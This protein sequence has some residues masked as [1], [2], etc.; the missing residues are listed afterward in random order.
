[1]ATTSPLDEHAQKGEY[2]IRKSGRPFT[3][4]FRVHFVRAHDGVPVSPFH[5]IP[6]YHDREK[7]ILNMVIE[8]PRWSNAKFEISREKSLN[9]IVQDTLDHAPRF[10]K[11]FFPY[12][13]YIWNY[14]AL[15]QTWEDPDHKDSDTGAPGDNDPLDACEIGRAVAPGPGTVRRVRPLGVLGLLD[16][17]ETDWKV[18]V[19]DVDD[20]VLGARLRDLADV[21]RLLP[22]LLDATRDWF[23]FYMVPDGR[24]PNEFAFGGQWKGR[25]FAE[26]IIAD[27]EDAW[28]KLVKGKTKREDISLDNTTLDGTPGKLDPDEV[29][30]P[31]DEDLSPAPIEQDLDEWFYIDRKTAEDGEGSLSGNNMTIVLEMQE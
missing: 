1:M 21:E 3:K 28:K 27:C 24:P 20:P 15:P 13:G 7:G 22:G 12:R 30:L 6:L 8:I 16:A 18:L 10:V 29:R 5:D 31:P 26:K 19:V 14:G 17:G 11:N 4:D 25:R 23:R 9:P 2:V